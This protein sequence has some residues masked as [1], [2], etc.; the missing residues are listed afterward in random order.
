MSEDCNVMVK[1][2]CN[3]PKGGCDWQ[4]IEWAR[5]EEVCTK[6]DYLI[7]SIEVIKS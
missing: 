7:M 6:C 4:K 2:F 3:I 1:M 5:A